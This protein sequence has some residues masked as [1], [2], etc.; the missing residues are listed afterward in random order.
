[1]IETN[2]LIPEITGKIRLG[3]LPPHN[4]HLTHKDQVSRGEL[5]SLGQLTHQAAHSMEKQIGNLVG[6]VRTVQDSLGGIG[7][8]RQ[9][10]FLTDH[11]SEDWA[12]AKLENY[13]L[14]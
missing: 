1:V 7:I 13:D 6:S 14:D 2:H 12:V 8:H 3:S 11:E 5:H 9:P 4:P 10:Q